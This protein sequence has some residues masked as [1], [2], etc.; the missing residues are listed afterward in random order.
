MFGGYSTANDAF[1][2]RCNS[3]PC[4]CTSGWPQK[5]QEGWICPRC[6]T[7]HAP[8]VAQCGCRVESGGSEGRE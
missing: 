8:W 3:I 6:Q 1:C 4:W 7:V 5:T 2:S